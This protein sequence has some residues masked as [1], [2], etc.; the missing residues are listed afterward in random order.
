MITLPNQVLAQ[1]LASSSPLHH[2]ATCAYRGRM[3]R[4]PSRRVAACCLHCATPYQLPHAHPMARGADAS[5]MALADGTVALACADRD[6][7]GPAILDGQGGRLSPFAT[8]RC[9][10]CGED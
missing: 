10:A 9:P 4:P 1:C 6:T 7:R 8:A 3:V 5:V 2:C